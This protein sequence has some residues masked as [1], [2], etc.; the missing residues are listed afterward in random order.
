MTNTWT[1][2][3]EVLTMDLT[4]YTRLYTTADFDA[5]DRFPVTSAGSKYAYQLVSSLLQR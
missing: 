3:D 4:A 1:L 2:D 5:T